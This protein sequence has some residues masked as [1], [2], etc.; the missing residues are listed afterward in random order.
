MSA[1]LPPLPDAPVAQPLRLVVL[2]CSS[3][4]WDSARALAAVPGAELC[5]VIRTPEAKARSAGKR[6]RNVWRYHGVAGLLRIPL[7][8]LRARRADRRPASE[9]DTALDGVPELR[10]RNFHDADC[11]AALRDLRADLAIVDGTYVLKPSVFAAP[12]WGS[13]NIH[14]GKLPDFRGAPPAFWEL[15]HGEPQV[16][17]T[18][19]RVTERLDEGPILAQELFPLDLTPPGD[20]VAY[21]HDYWLQVL[22]PAALRL[23]ARTV[24]E[25]AAGRAQPRPQGASRHETFRRPDH[26]TKQALRAIVRRR[27]AAR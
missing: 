23:L 18:I 10:F 12:R 21:V 17:V 3:F 6:L 27:R 7:N 15:Y 2:T 16:G 14:C 22:R 24:G 26:R 8:R 5:A 11:L 9:A 25:I 20:P 13:L 19:H 4:G 1:A